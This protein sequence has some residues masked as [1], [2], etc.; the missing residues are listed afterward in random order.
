MGD[1]GSKYPD[2]KPAHEVELDTFYIG[3]YPVTQGLWKAVMGSDN[4]PSYFKGDQRPVESVSW[5]QIVGEFFPRLNKMTGETRLKNHVFRLPTEAEWELAARG[6][7]KNRSVFFAGSDQLK[8]VGWFKENSH[9][10]TKDVGQKLPNDLG[11]FDMSGN[12]SEWCSDWWNVDYYENCTK[13][14][15]TQNPQGVE[16]GT[17]RVRRGGS[18]NDPGRHCSNAIRNGWPPRHSDPYLGFRIVLSFYSN[19]RSQSVL[20]PS[21]DEC[22]EISNSSGRSLLIW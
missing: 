6:D 14:E 15:I 11:I 18:W 2:D 1:D 7:I 20:N 16:Q 5:L 3:R 19:L 10:E 13:K 17:F 21:E 8:N 22:T 4:N 12:V 9:G